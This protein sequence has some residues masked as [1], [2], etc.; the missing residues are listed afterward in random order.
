MI[1]LFVISSVPFSSPP[2]AFPWRI[3]LLLPGKWINF[4]L[5]GRR[6]RRKD[7]TI[8]LIWQI[9][10]YGY[11]LIIVKKKEASKEL[12]WI[13]HGDFC[14]WRVSFRVSIL[15]LGI[16]SLWYDYFNI[17]AFVKCDRFFN[18][19]EYIVTKEDCIKARFKRF[20]NLENTLFFFPF[21]E[22][23]FTQVEN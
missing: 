10:I 3:L 15:E 21:W 18:I 1:P 8:T 16:H 2:S 11:Y 17:S 20:C 4:A 7:W 9:F 23:R 22:V 13:F 5:I 12:S 6:R 19:L 14:C